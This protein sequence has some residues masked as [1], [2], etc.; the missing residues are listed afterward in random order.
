MIAR[1]LTDEIV[2]Q[3]SKFKEITIIG[4]E[5]SGG[6]NSG[7]TDQ[8]GHAPY[9][10]EGRVRVEGD[11]LRLTIRF[12]SVSD[13][14]VIW[15]NSY[16]RTLRA[17]DLLDIE[18][19]IAKTVATALAQPYGIIFQT[20]ATQ[21]AQSPPGRWD[22]YTCTLAYY[23]YRANLNPQNH[24]SV[25]NC[26]KRATQ[27]FPQYATLW[28][29][30]SLTYLDEFRFRYQLGGP[31]EQSLELASEAAEHAVDLDPQNVR[32]LQARMLT[33]FFLGQVEA[34]LKVGASAVAINPNDTELTAEYGF[35]LAL[36]GQW[37]PGCELISDAMARNPGPK[38]FFEVALALCS[39]MK[40]D[41]AAAERWA[42]MADLQ[43]NPI[44]HLVLLAVLGAR[45]KLAEAREERRWLE[46][47]A[48]QLLKDVRRE[49]AMRICRV[50]DQTHFVDGLKA[51]GLVVPDS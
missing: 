1:G 21:I 33:Y 27:K 34:A 18:L 51:S 11:N 40:N 24:T 35:R 37:S 38:G 42:R 22:A 45:G 48:P 28:A 16:D 36:S 15:A 13:G 47:N 7:L 3:L 41:Y 39:Y 14:S 8:Y 46:G 49:V 44:H 23:D 31:A 4:G 29:L 32:A 20:G 6:E 2:G 5:P 19:D 50:E 9:A 30:L 10:I 43:E 26:L 12:L 25:Q 17:Q